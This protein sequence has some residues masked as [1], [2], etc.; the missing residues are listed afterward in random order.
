MKRLSFLLLVV[1]L[2]LVPTGCGKKPAP[3]PQPVTDGAADAAAAR[4]AGEEAA[5][6]AR[7]EAEEAA[8][9][10]A[11][12]RARREREM[13]AAR[14]TLLEIV[15]FD[16]DDA[17]IKPEAQALLDQKARILRQYPEVRV[18]IE[19]H[20]DERGSNEYNDALGHRRA[21]SILAYLTGA[22]IQGSRLEIISF[23]EDRPL[24]PGHDEMSWARNRRGEF[25]IVAGLEG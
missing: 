14:T 17:R 18:R 19:G 13:A 9:R 11:E 8:R 2:A 21:S 10:E 20:C 4:R 3:A 6:R 12:E 1:T 7:R 25:V 23:G 5:A 16:F 15:Y 24:A 22:G